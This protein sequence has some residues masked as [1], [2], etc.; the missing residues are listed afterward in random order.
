[1]WFLPSGENK[2][3]ITGF[4]PEQQISNYII[5][6]PPFAEEMNKTRKMCCD[7]ARSMTQSA[8]SSTAV[9]LIDLFGCGDSEGDLVD[10]TWTLW[11]KNITDLVDNLSQRFPQLPFTLLGLRLG[12]A[13]AL[14]CYVNQLKHHK[15]SLIFWQPTLNGEQF[16]TQFL[17]VKTIAAKL[18]GVTLTLAELRQQLIIEGQIEVSGYLLSRALFDDIKR[19]EFHKLQALP[20]SVSVAWFEVNAQEGASLAMVSN[21]LL[22]QWKES[23]SVYSECCYG[24][25]FWQSIEITSAPQL[26]SKTQS[27]LDE[28]YA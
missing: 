3:L 21:K 4:E 18:K 1:M 22:A 8:D 20:Q 2:L 17:R 7:F 10:A 14:D 15:L 28:Q 5:I 23:A 27:Y 6:V 12:A 11:Q 16:I 26:I 13:L 9:Y 24:E 25:L 19:I